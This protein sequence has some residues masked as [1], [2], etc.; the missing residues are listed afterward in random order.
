MAVTTYAASAPVAHAGPSDPWLEPPSPVIWTKADTIRALEH[1]S[2]RVRC[3][4]TSEVGDSG[5]DYDPYTVGDNGTSFG[6]SQL[7]WPGG[8]LRDYE[9]WSDGASAY[10]PYRSVEYIEHIVSRGG[11]SNWTAA[12]LGWC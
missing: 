3:I 4:V 5:S 6:V 7:H 11:A 10:N 1:A 8:L 12:R 2:P 9:R